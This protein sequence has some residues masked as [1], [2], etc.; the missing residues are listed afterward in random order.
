MRNSWF[1]ACKLRFHALD[2]PPLFLCPGYPNLINWHFALQYHNSFSSRHLIQFLCSS[3]SI[4]SSSLLLPQQRMIY[5]KFL[6]I[7][8]LHYFR[9]QMNGNELCVCVLWVS[10]LPFFLYRF[11][12]IPKSRL[13]MSISIYPAIYSLVINITIWCIYYRIRN[14]SITCG[15]HGNEKPICEENFSKDMPKVHI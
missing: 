8:A 7:R 6:C 2:A 12:R 3:H 10:G 11:L 14:S 5:C 4:V 15:C 9:I 1:F 13:L